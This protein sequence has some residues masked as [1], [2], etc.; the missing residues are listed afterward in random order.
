MRG[1]SSWRCIHFYPFIYWLLRKTYLSFK[2]LRRPRIRFNLA[3]E[4]FHSNRSHCDIFSKSSRLCCHF[5]FNGFGVPH[6]FF[7][8]NFVD[9][10]NLKMLLSL[11]LFRRKIIFLPTTLFSILFNLDKMC[12]LNT[13]SVQGNHHSAHRIFMNHMVVGNLFG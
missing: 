13:C 3:L 9:T 5:V 10:R 12:K 7:G 4:Y 6:S 2:K 11:R 1:P 8:N